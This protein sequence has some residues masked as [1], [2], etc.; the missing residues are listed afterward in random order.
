MSAQQAISH[1]VDTVKQQHADNSGVQ[2][3]VI[4][5]ADFQDPT[6]HSANRNLSQLRSALG[7][8]GLTAGLFST[9]ATGDGQFELRTAPMGV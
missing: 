3:T 4:D 5:I 2:S 9:K 7:R 6:T 1:I 8:L